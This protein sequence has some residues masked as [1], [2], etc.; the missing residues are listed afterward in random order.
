V[1]DDRG[2][3]PWNASID[4]LSTNEAEARRREAFG[5]K[6]DNDDSIAGDAFC[7][8][9]EGEFLDPPNFAVGSPC[10]YCGI[11]LAA[12]D[13][14]PWHAEDSGASDRPWYSSKFTRRLAIGTM[15]LVIGVGAKVARSGILGGEGEGEA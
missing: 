2:T 1:V 14:S 4:D 7:S 8:H 9:S 3:P 6:V 11:T 10:P 15:V 12:G 13:L 5:D